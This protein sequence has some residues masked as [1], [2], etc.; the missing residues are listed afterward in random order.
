MTDWSPATAIALER[1]HVLEGEERV[2]RQEVL[3]KKM[4]GRG[5]PEHVHIAAQ[6]PDALRES[7]ELSRERLRYLEAR[8]GTALGEK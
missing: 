1:R 8:Y 3:V 4:V 2:A 7:L 6:M 5:H